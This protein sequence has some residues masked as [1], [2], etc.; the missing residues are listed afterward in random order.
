MNIKKDISSIS[1]IKNIVLSPRWDTLGHQ[2]K[3]NFANKS[4]VYILN[5]ANEII[6]YQDILPNLNAVEIDEN[7]I[8]K[9]MK[10]SLEIGIPLIIPEHMNFEFFDEKEKIDYLK[11]VTSINSNVEDFVNLS[12]TMWE[13]NGYEHLINFYNQSC[14]N[15]TT[16]NFN[17]NFHCYILQKNIKVFFSNGFN[18][19]KNKKIINKMFDTEQHG[20][21][22]YSFLKKIEYIENDDPLLTTL[23]D[24]NL[25][26]LILSAILAKERK[27]ELLIKFFDIS[28]QHND[29]KNINRLI[30]QDQKV[31]KLL[32]NVLSE[33]IR[34]DD[35]EVPH[36]KGKIKNS[37]NYNFLQYLMCQQNNHCVMQLCQ[38]NQEVLNVFNHSLSEKTHGFVYSKSPLDAALYDMIPSQFIE[39]LCE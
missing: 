20:Y 33:K 5:N 18:I 6:D 17:E 10:K 30:E 32:I 8:E 35:K 11:L 31:K 36:Y 22:V 27:K 2:E 21:M 15:N 28:Q 37:E 14:I 1:D 34:S 12:Q 25:T 3:D 29:I 26:S 13:S 7:L 23:K 39:D 4:F 9:L 24:Y 38:I 16:S 19:E